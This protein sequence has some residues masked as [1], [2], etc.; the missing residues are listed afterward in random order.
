MS[1]RQLRLGVFTSC[2]EARL[3]SCAPFSKGHRH[4]HLPSTQAGV[5]N[6][7]ALFPHPSLPSSPS[8]LLQE[9]QASLPNSLLPGL[10]TSQH[11]SIP[12][13]GL[14]EPAP[15]N[16]HLNLTLN[17]FGGDQMLSL[18]NTRD[19]CAA[20]HSHPPQPTSLFLQP[21]GLPPLTE[22]SPSGPWPALQSLGF[23]SCYSHRPGVALNT[24]LEIILTS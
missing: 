20:W 5:Q 13:L 21:P 24:L 19:S 17:P 14:P 15:G 11:P 23:S 4:P 22:T 3:T 8:P 2:R 7:P 18:C 10:S 12:T 6:H 1:R 9:F 16:T